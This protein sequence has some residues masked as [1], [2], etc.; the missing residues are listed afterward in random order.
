MKVY[1]GRAAVHTWLWEQYINNHPVANIS[2]RPHHHSGGGEL[3]SGV[4]TA[5]REVAEVSDFLSLTDNRM[6][7]ETPTGDFINR[8]QTY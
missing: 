4:D 5:A 2:I 6:T 8:N 7:L 1:S 3:C